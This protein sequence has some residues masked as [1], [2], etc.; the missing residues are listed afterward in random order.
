[1]KKGKKISMLGVCVLFA[2]TSMLVGCKGLGGT[3]IQ[4]IDKNKTQIYVSLYNGGLGT[5]WFDRLAAEWN[6]QNEK[7]EVIPQ[8]E[9]KDSSAIITE[10]TMEQ[11]PTSPSIYYSVAGLEVKRLVEGGY[12][13][14]LTDLLT[15]KPDGENGKTVR[16]KLNTTDDYFG[17]WSNLAA[18]S[19][20]GGLYILPWNEAISGFIYDHDFFLDPDNDGDTSDTFLYV[21]EVSDGVKADLTAQ[22]IAYK[23]ED[24]VLKFV[25]SQSET[26]YKADGVI[27]RAG[28]DGKYGTYDDGQPDGMDEWNEMLDAILASGNRTFIWTKQ[29]QSAY[30]EFLPNSLM[31]QYS[32]LQSVIDFYD[33]DS[34]GVAYEMYD[35]TE[36]AFTVEDGYKS[37]SMAG[38]NKTAEFVQEYLKNTQQ[39]HP[40]VTESSYDHGDVQ[41][42]FL[43]GYRGVK[44]NP[45]TAMILEGSWWENEA[46][47]AFATNEKDGRG[48]GKRD[49]RYMLTPNLDGAMGANGD[50]T[51]TAMAISEMSYNFVPK[52]NDQ[53]KLA[54]IKDFLTFSLRDENLRAYT[55]QTGVVRPYVYNLTKEDRAEMT[56]FARCN[57]DIYNDRENI[58]LVKSLLYS[59]QPILYA[60]NGYSSMPIKADGVTYGSIVAALDRVSVQKVTEG[61]AGAYSASSWANY[62]NTA[63]AAG[64][65]K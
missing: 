28:R 56:P 23:E 26:N 49:Y 1:M 53:E 16:E 8:L 64:F 52:C 48:Y 47:V 2:L 54:A 33:K 6:K 61:I 59:C 3:V 18:H 58:K 65:Y 17:L 4:G 13:E 40:T 24:G 15:V 35:G 36:A 32:G 20:N 25:S 41:S 60:T 42:L 55:R 44:T 34:G 11:T 45:Q 39:T 46:R 9:K 51:G 43:M 63:K 57:W 50:G 7:Y 21:A 38:F 29:F 31:A 62:L 14:D 27:L 10:V 22:G 19:S 5:E 30:T 12:L 37:F